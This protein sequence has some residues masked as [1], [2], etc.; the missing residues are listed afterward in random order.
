MYLYC[1]ESKEELFARFL[2]LKEAFSIMRR[3]K[4]L[5]I[6]KSKIVDDAKYFLDEQDKR[7]V[8]NFLCQLNYAKNLI[9][10]GTQVSQRQQKNFAKWYME[11]EEN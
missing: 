2:D 3:L 5:E 10:Q 9:V 11:A 8:Q 4:V 1:T 6:A 7:D